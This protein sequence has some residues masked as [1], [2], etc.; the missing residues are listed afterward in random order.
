MAASQEA[1]IWKGNKP[2]I[3]VEKEIV[4]KVSWSLAEY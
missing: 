4:P 1:E 2:S 3:K